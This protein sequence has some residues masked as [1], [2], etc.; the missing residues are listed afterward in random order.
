MPD[1]LALDQAATLWINHHHNVGLDAV[2]FPLSY[3]AERGGV[4]LLFAVG[5]LIWGR[6][7]ERLATVAFLAAL[8][9]TELALMP[10]FR[11]FLPRPRPYMYLPDVRQWGLRWSGT[12][13]PSGHTYL[14]TYATIF[15]G[16]LWRRWR[17][18]LI[19][20]TLLTMYARPYCGMHHVSDVLGGAALGVIVGFPLLLLIKK[21][22]WLEGPVEPPPP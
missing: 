6:R 14:W 9:F 13:F 19:A 21:W 1:W 4:W 7:R 12:S 11:E 3:S 8:I 15:Y 16:A 17:W 5:L 20:L 22:R 10:L 2:L 18:P